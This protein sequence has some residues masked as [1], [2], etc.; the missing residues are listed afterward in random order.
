MKIKSRKLRLTAIPALALS[1]LISTGAAAET[2]TQDRI[3]IYDSRLIAYVAFSSETQQRKVNDLT[4]KAK[5]AKDAGQTEQFKNFGTA[6]KQEQERIHLQVF[7]TAPVDDVLATMTNR[8]AQVQKQACISKLVSKWDKATL[9]RHE[10]A[11]KVDVTDLL[12]GE[13]KLTDRQRKVL[14]DMKTKK[15]LPIEKAQE[16]IRKGEL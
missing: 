7:S 5:A 13:F 1:L 2:N 6:L 10:K 4:L 15:P 11:E 14:E 8:V 16:M 3:G 9:E 12:L